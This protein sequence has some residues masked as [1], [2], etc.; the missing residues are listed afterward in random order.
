MQNKMAA[1]L[2][3][4]KNLLGIELLSCKNV[5]LLQAICIVA[6]HRIENDLLQKRGFAL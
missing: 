4:Q 2:V 3:Y 1:M 6:G 5:L